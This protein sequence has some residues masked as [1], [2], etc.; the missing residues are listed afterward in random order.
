MDLKFGLNR[1]IQKSKMIWLNLGNP[2]SKK[3]RKHYS[4]LRIKLLQNE[5]LG[6]AVPC[7][8]ETTYQVHTDGRRNS[9]GAVH[10]ETVP[11][12]RVC[13]AA[14]YHTLPA[15]PRTALLSHQ[16]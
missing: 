16:F 3:L 14:R 11:V 7:R 4:N 15:P 5:F 1:N 10:G 2:H 8:P 12:D 9:E 6:R 13:T